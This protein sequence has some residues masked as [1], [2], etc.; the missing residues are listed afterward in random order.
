MA[1]PLDLIEQGGRIG[2]AYGGGLLGGVQNA[3]QMWGHMQDRER[4]QKMDAIAEE[5]RLREI[6]RQDES[7]ARQ[8]QQWGQ[9]DQLFQRQ[10]QQHE[11][12]LLSSRFEL[13]KNDLAKAIAS[14]PNLSKE[15]AYARARRLYEAENAF[16][17][18][19]GSQP[20]AGPRLQLDE[21]TQ[22]MQDAFGGQQA[23]GPKAGLMGKP[24]NTNE[25]APGGAS[26]A[27]IEKQPGLLGGVVDSAGNR[28]ALL[29]RYYQAPKADV[30]TQVINDQLVA[31][32][33]KPNGQVVTQP[34]GDYR[35]PEYTVTDGGLVINKRDGSVVADHRQP[36]YRA[37]DGGLIYDQ[38]TGQ[39]VNDY[40]QPASDSGG[41]TTYQQAQLR[42]QVD[43]DVAAYKKALTDGTEQIT[44]KGPETE[45]AAIDRMVKERKQQLYQEYGLNPTSSQPS[46]QS[47]GGG[48]WSLEEVTKRGGSGL[49]AQRVGN[50]NFV[51]LDTLPSL[52]VR[53]D[54]DPNARA[55]FRQ[56]VQ[57]AKRDGVTL[58]F[59]EDPAHGLFHRG[60]GVQRSIR[61]ANRHKYRTEEE[62]NKYVAR[63]GHS[64]HESGIAVDFGAPGYGWASKTGNFHKSPAFKWL[65]QNAW[66]YGALNYSVESWH[67]VYMPDVVQRAVGGQQQQAPKPANQPQRQTQQPKPKLD[68]KLNAKATQWESMVK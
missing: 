4:Q 22:G 40:R 35:S 10:T 55:A 8:R 16:R 21:A 31:I 5:N 57:D 61:A 6:R 30:K 60:P 50:G 1:G 54:A 47:G 65:Q 23:Y 51:S 24:V 43:K 58:L 45:A 3:V 53:R 2:R 25:M 7:D 13:E 26:F 49:K 12:G 44:L 15:E 62:M 52:P 29:G 56:M 64:T 9:Q 28:S 38:S 34:L 19:I 18:S 48:G 27:D 37:T 66:K 17:Q 59:D 46:G 63:E 32:I 68:P 39:M 20:L 33:T 36:E 14:N 11:Q 41:L 42:L 67:W